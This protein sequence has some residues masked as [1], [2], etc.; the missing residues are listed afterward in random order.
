[1]KYSPAFYP[2]NYYIV[3]GT[4]HIELRCPWHIPSAIAARLNGFAVIGEIL[5]LPCY[6]HAPAPISAAETQ[7]TKGHSLKGRNAIRK[8][9]NEETIAS[10]TNVPIATIYIPEET[11][12]SA[13]IIVAVKTK[14]A[15]EMRPTPSTIHSIVM[16]R[17]LSTVISPKPVTTPFVAKR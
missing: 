3:Q 16:I 10:I 11:A 14:I 13:W 7:K 12:V 1:V 8:P 17:R 2:L 4:E 15:I 5:P 9:V 6:T